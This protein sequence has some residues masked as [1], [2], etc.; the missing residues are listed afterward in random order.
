MNWLTGKLPSHKANDWEPSH[1]LDTGTN[2]LLHQREVYGQQPQKTPGRPF[3]LRS[4]AALSPSRPAR[5]GDAVANPP[6]LG[7]RG[8]GWAVEISLV[9]TAGGGKPSPITW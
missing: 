9:A 6:A 8:W 5:L 7:S 3:L 2:P 1:V 4:Q